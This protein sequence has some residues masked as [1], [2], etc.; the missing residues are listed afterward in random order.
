MGSFE[1]FCRTLP[2]VQRPQVQFNAWFG[3]LVANPSNVTSLANLI[4]F[5]NEYPILEE[6]AG[7]TNQSM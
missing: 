4:A 6:P 7:Y 3:R 1:C 5:D 2:G